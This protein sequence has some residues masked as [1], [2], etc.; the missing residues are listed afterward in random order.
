MQ[1]SWLPGPIL[2]IVIDAQLGCLNASAM[3]S[4]SEKIPTT[5]TS[6]GW[7]RKLRR[8]RGSEDSYASTTTSDMPIRPSN[9]PPVFNPSL[10]PLRF[11]QRPSH[12]YHTSLS[13]SQFQL[14]VRLSRPSETTIDSVGANNSPTV[15]S[16]SL[17]GSPDALSTSRPS[18]PS[19]RMFERS[20][21][22]S[23][24]PSRSN[25]PIHSATRRWDQIRNAIRTGGIPAP[26]KPSSPVTATTTLQR[27][28]SPN[29]P[30]R[31]QTPKPSRLARLPFRQAVD[32]ARA[33]AAT[34]S[35][36]YN[37]FEI[38]V[39]QACLNARTGGSSRPK[40]EKEG[41]QGSVYLPFMSTASFSATGA[42][43]SGKGGQFNDFP[44]D[45]PPSLKDLH[46]VLIRYASAGQNTA[47]WRLPYESEVLSAL[48]IPYMVDSRRDM[49]EQWL[50]I[51]TFEIAVQTWNAQNQQASFLRQYPPYLLLIS[52][53]V[54]S[55]PIILVL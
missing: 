29:L 13:Q 36:Q 17:V 24:T 54:C 3:S 20:A 46:Q 34:T 10:A 12:E 47:I 25:T 9:E 51:E 41:T 42:L 22:G 50:A 28:A 7:F 44:R 33:Q 14:P 55:R 8:R 43:P 18:T 32:N 52:F 48:L 4:D 45:T 21:T 53:A 27:T 2:L 5:A 31:P 37:R 26:D 16:E 23:P 40:A 49:E 15:F 35:E 11:S 6:S 38:E 30:V 39:Y 1:G 19:R